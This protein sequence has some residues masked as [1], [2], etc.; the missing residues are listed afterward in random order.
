MEEA[1]FIDVHY[2]A[3]LGIEY[4]MT[5]VNFSH[6]PGQGQIPVPSEVLKFLKCFHMPIRTTARIDKCVRV[7][8]LVGQ[9]S[10][11]MAACFMLNNSA[12]IV[13]IGIGTLGTK[14]NC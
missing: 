2:V 11:A 14:C 3:V 4:Q 6:V 8:I 10:E 9:F 5:P 12:E 1:A 7:Y 13:G